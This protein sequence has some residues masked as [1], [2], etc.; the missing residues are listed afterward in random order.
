M[1]H[2]SGLVM[3]QIA[4]LRL[5]INS[6]RLSVLEAAIKIDEGDAKAA[7]QEIAIAKVHVPRVLLRAVDYAIQ[8]YGAAGIS[9]DTPLAY[10][11]A[12]ARTMRIVD[13]PDE[14]HLL[15][16]GKQESK[17]ASAVRS[18]LVEQEAASR[19][20]MKSYNLHKADPLHLGW[21]WET[22]PKL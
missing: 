1:L 13:G 10:M 17:R 14:V 8:I 7:M 16:L 15:Q 12:T 9:Q 2:E 22:K 11:M 6:A 4:E 5:E 3:N 19:D 18:R 20:L 21:T